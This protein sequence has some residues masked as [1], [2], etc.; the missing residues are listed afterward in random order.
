MKNIVNIAYH[1]NTIVTNQTIQAIFYKLNRYQ[2]SFVRIVLVIHGHT[3]LR[4]DSK[5][6]YNN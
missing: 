5:E 3:H 2:T 1:N 6:F 4:E